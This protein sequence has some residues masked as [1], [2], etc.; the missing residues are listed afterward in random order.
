MLL[1]ESL[2]FRNHLQGFDLLQV[3]VYDKDRFHD[4]KIGSA[5]INLTNLY[6]KQRVDQWFTLESSIRKVDRGQIHLIIE[7]KPLAI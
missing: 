6:E 3:E 7:Y 5:T 4:D 2:C 1:Y